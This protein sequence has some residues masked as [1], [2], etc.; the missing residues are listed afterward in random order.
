VPASANTR[1]V[2]TFRRLDHRRRSLHRRHQQPLAR[3]VG[4][5]LAEQS[6]GSVGRAQRGISGNTRGSA[7]APE[8]SALA[9]FGPGRADA[10]GRDAR[11]LMEGINDIGVA[12]NGREPERRR[13]HRGQKQLITR[14]CA[15]PQIIGATLT[16]MTARPTG[17]P[18]GEAK[19]QALNQW[20][21]TSR[22]LRRRDRFRQ[23]HARR[24]G[25]EQVRAT[26]DSGRPPAS[27]ATPGYKAMAETRST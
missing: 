16:P 22:R 7:T 17:T 23:G 12:R 1:A 4:S 5:R 14:A 20:I 10:N 19:R 2:V 25:A 18:E 27:A 15:R 9:R 26:A 3:R 6:G 8:V 24:G 11:R 13:P 21:R